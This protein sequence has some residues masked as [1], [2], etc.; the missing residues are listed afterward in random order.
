[1]MTCVQTPTGMNPT[2][3]AAANSRHFQPKRLARAMYF[4]AEKGRLGQSGIIP[5]RLLN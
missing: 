5:N 1:M 2:G 4:A 3:P